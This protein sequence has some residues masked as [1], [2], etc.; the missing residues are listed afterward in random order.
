VHWIYSF[1]FSISSFSIGSFSLHCMLHF[2]QAE[3]A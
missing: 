2:M 1:S 3:D